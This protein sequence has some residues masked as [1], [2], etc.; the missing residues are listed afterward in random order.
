MRA[1][2]VPVFTCNWGYSGISHTY[3]AMT[4]CRVLYPC[5]LPY[6]V[7][8]RLQGHPQHTEQQCQ[9]WVLPMG[10]A[11]PHT[12]AAG[13][14]LP[15]GVPSCS[16][17]ISW[18]GW[19]SGTRQTAHQVLRI[20]GKKPTGF[21]VPLPTLWRKKKHSSKAH[22]VILSACSAYILLLT[23]C[24]HPGRTDGHVGGAQHSCMLQ[25]VPKLHLR[26][27]RF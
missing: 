14:K 13:S 4:S 7:I 24:S 9:L 25:K 5:W 19:R 12:T 18:D 3:M 22:S 27:H 2:Q 1:L 6:A 10:S 23:Y 8:R 16:T 17:G 26:A 21:D 20:W 15:H 11:A